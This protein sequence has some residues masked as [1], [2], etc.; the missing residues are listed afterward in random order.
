MELSLNNKRYYKIGEVAKA[1]GVNVS[2]IR[3][4]ENEFD[5]IKPKK[6][7]KGDRMFT[8]ADIDNLK[9]I[10]HLVKEKGFTLE[11]VKKQFSTQYQTNF[12][13]Q[14]IIFKLENIK[15]E[16]NKLKNSL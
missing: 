14:S 9:I 15:N 12:E 8:N 13:K 2:L 4:W 16:L 5:I 3:Y 10:Y 7:S 1:F 11:G 6:N